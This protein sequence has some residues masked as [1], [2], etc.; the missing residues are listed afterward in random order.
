L[1]AILAPG[2][3]ENRKANLQDLATLT[4]GEAQI[5]ELLLLHLATQFLS[6]FKNS[7]K[8]TRVMGTVELLRFIRDPPSFAM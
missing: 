2:F 8:G 3:G 6:L 7:P 4:G 5:N 1:Y